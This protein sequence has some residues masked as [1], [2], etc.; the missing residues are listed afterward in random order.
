M[1]L[2]CSLLSLRVK[3]QVPAASLR[4]ATGLGEAEECKN[5][6][7]HVLFMCAPFVVPLIQIFFCSLSSFPAASACHPHTQA[8]SRSHWL[9]GPERNPQGTH[10]QGFLTSW[11]EHG[12]GFPT[13]VYAVL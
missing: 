6:G 11:R 1:D 8:S 12:R 13:P 9:V 7:I 5:P 3:R 10:Q 2:P 4:K